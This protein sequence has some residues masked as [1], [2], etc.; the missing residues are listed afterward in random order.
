MKRFRDLQP[1]TPVPPA[2]WLVG[3]LVRL[4]G[5]PEPVRH[6]WAVAVED[7][8]RAEWAAIDHAMLLGEIATSPC[9]GI[10]PV[11]SLARLTPGAFAWSGLRP[12]DVRA[13]GAQWPRRWL[14]A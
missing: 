4:P 5:E 12:G 8:A 11:E 1:N 14:T 2:G 7:R 3:V 6:F 9:R 10:E 13:L